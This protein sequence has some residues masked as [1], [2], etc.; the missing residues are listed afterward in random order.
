VQPLHAWLDAAAELQQQG[1]T[2][3]SSSLGGL[4]R[5]LG[6]SAQVVQQCEAV[7]TM[8]GPLACRKLPALSSTMLQSVTGGQQVCSSYRFDHR[9]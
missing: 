5:A 4:G 3:T 7:L 9:Y 2:A 8:L 6:A 1:A